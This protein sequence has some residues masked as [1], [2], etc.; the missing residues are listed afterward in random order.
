MSL[1]STPGYFFWIEDEETI[2]NFNCGNKFGDR[3]LITITGFV[4]HRPAVNALVFL[5]DHHLDLEVLSIFFIGNQ[6]D[7]FT[8]HAAF[9]FVAQ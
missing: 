8:Q 7:L 4:E 9:R 3:I 2:F 1:I 5:V 6:I